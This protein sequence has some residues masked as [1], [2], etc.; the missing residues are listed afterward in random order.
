MEFSYTAEYILPH[1][2]Y[3][4]NLGHS[5]E[6]GRTKSLDYFKQELNICNSLGI[7]MLNIHPGSTRRK[8]SREKC[9]ELIADSINKAFSEI[10][11]VLIFLL[12]FKV[13]V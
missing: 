7:K 9:I 12:L 1:G 6:E 2:C 5:E 3:L 4:V 11:E 10:P 13:F 8:I